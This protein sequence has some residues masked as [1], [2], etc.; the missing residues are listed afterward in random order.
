MERPLSGDAEGRLLLPRHAFTEEETL[1]IAIPLCDALGHAHGEKVL[2][3]D[4]KPQNIMI[5]N[6]GKVKLTDFGIACVLGTPTESE[7]TG[8]ILGTPKYFSPEQGRGFNPTPASDVYSLGVVMYEALT[9]FVPFQADSAEE[10][11]RL[12][13]ETLPQSPRELNPQVS[14]A[15]ETITLRAMAKEPATRY[16]DA[17]LMADALRE[18][19]EVTAGGT[20]LMGGE[21][22]SAS[23]GYGLP[24][25]SEPESPEPTLPASEEVPQTQPG[26]R[27]PGT[28]RSLNERLGFDLTTWI[29]ALIA[30]LFV[31][32]LIP[33][34]LWVYF[35][36]TV[37]LRC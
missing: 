4:I 25:D 29:L 18:F 15:L 17:N 8:V 11:A 32:G 9:G 21:A 7:K 19:S 3:R 35:R 22:V 30:L 5:C 14:P 16:Q 37:N 6:D 33:F 27:K 28:K 13:R 34:W 23:A 26:K 36:I 31:G 1:N 20:G 2:H 24:A 10:L 12:H